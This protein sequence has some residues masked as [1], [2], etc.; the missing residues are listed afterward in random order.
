MPHLHHDSLAQVALAVPVGDFFDYLCPRHLPLPQV[1]MRVLVPF[2]RRLLIGI[3]VGL[4]D[5]T[6]SQV[7]IAKL[8]PI[9]QILDD[10]PIIDDESGTTCQVAITLL[11][12]SAW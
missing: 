5:R 3:V 11:S 6:D 1:G 2:G 4:I 7:P 9:E 12:P 8:K 10:T